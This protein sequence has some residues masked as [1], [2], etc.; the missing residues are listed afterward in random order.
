MKPRLILFISCLIE[1][2]FC[3]ISQ[4]SFQNRC[5]QFPL[6][7]YLEKQKSFIPKKIFFRLLSI[8]KQKSFI[9]R[10]NFKQ[11]IWSDGHSNINATLVI[12]QKWTLISLLS[13]LSRMLTIIGL[14]LK[15]MLDAQL[16]IQILNGLYLGMTTWV[17]EKSRSF[18]SKLWAFSTRQFPS[19]CS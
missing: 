5:W 7:T 18:R 4:N 2:K 10:P 11:R 12:N 6:F 14:N 8:S 3:E 1:L 15:K 17:W 19:Y 9:Y 13:K 16:E